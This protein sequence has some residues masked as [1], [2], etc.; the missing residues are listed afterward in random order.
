MF[1][2]LLAVDVAVPVWAKFSRD[3]FPE[4]VDVPAP[5]TENVPCTKELPVVVAPPET[6]KP[7][8]CAPAP[9]VEDEYA[10]K[11]PLKERSVEVAFEGNKYPNTA[12]ASA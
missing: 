12:D 4:N 5:V 3:T 2:P 7:V 11:P 10:V 9:T 6:V 8:V 1:Q